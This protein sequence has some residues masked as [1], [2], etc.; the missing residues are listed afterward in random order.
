MDTAHETEDVQ[1]IEAIHKEEVWQR[2]C[3]FVQ[4]LHM[5]GFASPKQWNFRRRN[6]IEPSSMEANG[7]TV[8]RAGPVARR[9]QGNVLHNGDL[10]RII[11][12]FIPR[13]FYYKD[14][15]SDGDMMMMMT[16][17]MMMKVLMKRKGTVVI[18]DLS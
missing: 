8:S 3:N 6:P 5:S 11:S 10:C 1:I 2:L 14:E 16:V 18:H 13:D 12:T 15:V 7:A 9:Q 17:L 4:F